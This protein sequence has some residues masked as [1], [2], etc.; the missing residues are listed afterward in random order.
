MM[1]EGFGGLDVQKTT[2]FVEENGSELEKYRLNYL[3]GKVRDDEVPL[4]CLRGLQND[5]GGFP[6]DN[7]KGKL[8]CVGNTSANLSARA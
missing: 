4:R 5:E 1:R 3:L 8:S 6:Y 7:E 2:W